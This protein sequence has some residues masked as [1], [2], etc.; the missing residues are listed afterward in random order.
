[1]IAPGVIFLH[2]LQ[3]GEVALVDLVEGLI[4]PIL[5]RFAPSGKAIIDL[6][7]CEH[8]TCMDWQ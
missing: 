2:L 8:W 1:M 6:R 3:F 5:R 7:S 4:L